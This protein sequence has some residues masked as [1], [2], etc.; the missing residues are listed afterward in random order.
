MK[1]M[2]TSG[3][4]E[5]VIRRVQWRHRIR[6]CKW[7][8]LCTKSA[9][10]EKTDDDW[11]ESPSAFSDAGYSTVSTSPGISAWSFTR[12]INVCILPHDWNRILR[13]ESERDSQWTALWDELDL[14]W[15]NYDLIWNSVEYNE[16]YC[17]GR[18]PQRMFAIEL[19]WSCLDDAFVS[20]FNVLV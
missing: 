18:I 20:K 10:K 15:S 9:A 1:L 8:L 13:S 19:S 3:P 16:T 12:D 6:N 7:I 2:R 4:N 11:L 14:P 17:G 5:T